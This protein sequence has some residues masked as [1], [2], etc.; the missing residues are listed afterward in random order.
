MEL[1][2]EQIPR[3][4]TRSCV[5]ISTI[6]P[7]PYVFLLV[8]FLLPFVFREITILVSRHSGSVLYLATK[9]VRVE[10]NQAIGLNNSLFNEFVTFDVGIPKYTSKKKERGEIKIQ[11]ID[12]DITQLFFPIQN[13]LLYLLYCYYIY[14]FATYILSMFDMAITLS[15]WNVE[16][17]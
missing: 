8:R 9:D 7:F 12:G 1:I 17:Y 3:D 6:P 4:D 14:L 2:V 15:K 5:F 13:S 10:L 16:Y 11:Y